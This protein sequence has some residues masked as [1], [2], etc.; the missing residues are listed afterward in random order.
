MIMTLYGTWPG[1]FPVK[2][3]KIPNDNKVP[4]VVNDPQMQ[5]WGA[6]YH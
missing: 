1:R 6:K 3:N 5:V 4:T 2:N